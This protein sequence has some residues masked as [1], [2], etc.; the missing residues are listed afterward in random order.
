MDLQ[1]YVHPGE[2]PIYARQYPG[3]VIDEDQSLGTLVGLRSRLILTNQNSSRLIIVPEGNF[4]WEASAGHTTVRVDKRS[5]IRTHSYFID[6]QLC[7]LIDNGSL[8]SKL[9]LCYLHALTSSCLPDPFTMRTGTEQALSILNS[10]AVKSFDRL[11]E[12]NVDLL[13]RIARISPGRKYYPP[14]LREMQVVTWDEGISF[15]SQHGYFMKYVKIIFDHDRRM[16]I[17]HEDRWVPPPSMNHTEDG[18]AYRDC[19]RSA[20]LRISGFG[21]EDHTASRDREYAHRDRGSLSHYGCRAFKIANFI[22]HG[23]TTLEYDLPFDP[24]GHLWEFLCQ[25]SGTTQGPEKQLDPS[26]LRYDGELI[27]SPSGS[28]SNF[29]CSFYTSLTRN[30]AELNK[31]HVMLWLATMAF[32]EKAGIIVLQIMSAFYTLPGGDFPDARLKST[33]DLSKGFVV[34]DEELRRSIQQ[35]VRTIDHCVE[36]N[37]AM[38]SDEG[39]YSFENRK[40]ATCK[41]NR[42]KALDESLKVLHSEWPCESPTIP[43]SHEGVNIEPYINVDGATKNVGSMFYVWYSNHLFRQ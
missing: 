27:I 17:F 13:C 43:G 18:L 36:S 12:E 41:N 34:S 14:Y 15:L 42:D 5:I 6:N 8:Q 40:S 16:K 25:T 31:F 38:E 11:T 1:F 28:V 10:A 26:D 33:F 9:V 21:G 35:S 23:H 29:W 19:I 24:Q 22:Y 37:L 2:Q 32:S 3:M 4:T 30:R 39:Y 7:R 20:T